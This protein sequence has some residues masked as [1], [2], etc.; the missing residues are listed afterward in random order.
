[1]TAAVVP[2][3]LGPDRPIALVIVKAAFALHHRAL[4]TLAGSHPALHGDVFVD[5][6][7]RS[8]I[9]M[10][11]DFVPI[12]PKAELLVVGAC[13]PPEGRATVSAVAVEVGGVR[14]GVGVFGDR[15]WKRGLLGSAP[16]EP[17]PFERISITYDRAFG[18]EGFAAN[19]FG[20][21]LGDATLPNLEDIQRPLAS[22]DDRPRPMALGPL[23]PTHAAR[24]RFAGT[25][26]ERWRRERFPHWPE[27]FDIRY[28]QA[29]PEDQQRQRGYWTG[30]EEI[31]LKNLHPT[32]PFV[33]SKLPGLVARA[34]A[35]RV[36]GGPLERIGL[37][38]DTLVLD[39]ERMEA[40]AT[41]RGSL[42]LTRASLAELH[43][44]FVFH[45]DARTLTTPAAAAE[46]MNAALVVA[47]L[48]AA[49]F[50]PRRPQE[51][52]TAATAVLKRHAARSG[53]ASPTLAAAMA[54][55]EQTLAGTTM[56]DTPPAASDGATIGGEAMP[57]S[58][59][60]VSET[61][62]SEAP[63]VGGT[64]PIEAGAPAP[65]P[66]SAARE[67][68]TLG[69]LVGVSVE[70]AREAF[71][72]LGLTVPAEVEAALASAA[73]TA[74]EAALSAHVEALLA[75]I[76]PELSGPADV[77][78]ARAKALADLGLS[79][80]A[81]PEEL[82]A[83][84]DAR[85]AQALPRLTTPPDVGALEARLRAAGV[86][87]AE[88]AHLVELV[89]SAAGQAVE[90]A[91]E[92]EPAPSAS[93]HPRDEATAREGASEGASEASPRARMEQE[94]ARGASFGGD[95]SGLDL[96]G[97]ALP[98]WSAPGA[99]LARASLAGAVLRDADL[100]GAQ[101]AGA[102]LSGADLS[103][104]DLSRAD[105]TGAKLDGARLTEAKL[106]GATL[107][108]ATLQAAELAQAT[109]VGASLVEA[110]LDRAHA[111][112]ASLRGAD[113]S[114]ASLRELAADSADLTDATLH[115]ADASGAVLTRSTLTGLRAKR[116]A[117]FDGADL[118]HASAARARFA[119]SSL[120]GARLA[121]GDL[122]RADFSDAD[123]SEAALACCGLRAARF[124]RARL[125]RALL[126]QCDL[127]GASLRGATLVQTD[128]RGSSLHAAEL[129][130]AVTIGAE[131]EG[132]DL[133]S[134]KLGGA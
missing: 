35:Q 112:G 22:R 83:V 18:G 3:Q 114:G 109:L 2:E 122:E 68:G 89:S 36:E 6:E 17:E 131:L 129:L 115:G 95:A 72:Q 81:T 74:G 43:R 60:P 92:P 37:V 32:R 105:L 59:T 85:L 24:L 46:R 19:P 128:L 70:A 40:H 50:R 96:K 16:S 51:S 20:R 29:A 111:P 33:R 48:E 130:D 103:G 11:S 99:L 86:P 4:A 13:Y 104:A 21:G 31:A 119:G 38:L 67:A 45:E 113:L 69:E 76:P 102:D 94:H 30:E 41:W 108:G 134:T 63:P 82:L 14:K 54:L 73:P 26:D 27:D 10:A 52:T 106:T 15:T 121:F 80:S 132:A 12:K 1:M 66:V 78:G 123:L 34:Y 39:G 125:D 116:G 98:G 25:Y 84:L 62:V 5:D 61:P 8:A 55:A 57:V 91:R 110:R 126:T 9:A 97:I 58:E 118:R 53:L 100:R 28:F 7:P 127:M 49:G 77:E 71:A 88:V 42:P 44:V 87:S 124:D 120:R 75:R 79:A 101:L 93:A 64:A 107:D 23:A 90:P 133:S 65:P 47:Q 117:S 56:P